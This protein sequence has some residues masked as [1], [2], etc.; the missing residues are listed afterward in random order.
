MR[1]VKLIFAILAGAVVLAGC[2]KEKIDSKKAFCKV[3]TYNANHISS[4]MAV[5]LGRVTFSGTAP[6]ETGFLI[7][8]A[9]SFNDK[10]ANG[11]TCKLEN[12]NLILEA[13][14]L[15]PNTEYAFKAYAVKDG[16]R[17]LGAKKTFKTAIVQTTGI[18]LSRT[19]AT[20]N[21]ARGS[22]GP[23]NMTFQLSATV[24]PESATNQSI[25]WRTESESLATVSETGLVTATGKEGVVKI[26]AEQGEISEY[27]TVTISPVKIASV[28]ISGGGDLLM[29]NGTTMKISFSV[30]PSNAYYSTYTW[31]WDDT[32][33]ISMNASGT[34]TGLSGGRTIVRLLLD[35][36][37]WGSTYVNVIPGPPTAYDLVGEGVKWAT[38][39]L[40]ANSENEVGFQY[41]YNRKSPS[42]VFSSEAYTNTSSNAGDPATYAWGGRWKTPTYQQWN[43]LMTKC[44]WTYENG[45]WKVSGNGHSIFLPRLESGSGCYYWSGSVATNGGYY[46]YGTSAN[47]SLRNGESWKGYCVRPV[48]M[49]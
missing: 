48:L 47:T 30:T 19:T 29:A 21:P 15:E 1:T 3:E 22:E 7:D 10:T 45:G 31:R 16:E 24:L 43:D 12:E 32:K 49:P 23:I 4:A 9:S 38:C 25:S 39:N 20:M 34:V 42:T 8:K 41:A 17:F 36:T 27:C 18:S 5:L 37:S 26:Y 40:G 44:T 13:T 35:N 2:G 33:I 11:R 6:T 46:F 14:G 28:T